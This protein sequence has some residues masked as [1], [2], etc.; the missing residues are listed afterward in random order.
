[1][2][3]LIYGK[4]GEKRSINCLTRAFLILALTLSSFFALVD[5]RPTSVYAGA[6]TVYFISVNGDV[7]RGLENFVSRGLNEARKS[8]ADAVVLEIDTFGG[9]VDSAVKIRDKIVSCGLK[10]IAYVNPRAWSAGALIAIACDEIAMNL[11]SSIGAAETRP[12][13]EKYISAF[14]SEFQATAE[15]KGK[16]PKVAAAMV[17][18]QIEI[19]GLSA[20][21]K[22]LTLTDEEALSIGFADYKVTDRYDLLEQAGF[23]GATE[24]ELIPEPIEKFAGFLNNQTVSIVLL[25]LGFVGLLVEVITPGFGAPGTIGLASLVLFFGSRIVSGTAGG[26]IVI[27]FLV[28]L[29]M[30]LA[31]IFLIPGF[32]VVGV[33]GL[34]SFGGGIVLSFPTISQGI[35]ALMI[36]IVM[37]IVIVY[38]LFKALFARGYKVK[39]GPLSKLILQLEETPD[40]GYVSIKDRKYLLGKVGYVVTPLRPI[41]TVMIENEKVDASSEGGFVDQGMKVEVIEADGMRIVVRVLQED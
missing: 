24:V 20:L 37:T 29:A 13:E 22:I 27:L 7:D 14:R 32:G 9:Y 36:A 35:T 10:T 21:G 40:R 39:A 31:E 2:I 34:L 19:E 28:G 12:N 17:D 38:F 1:M 6:G 26:E 5:L 8:R 15:S 30:I 41:G 18:S 3:D 11:G 25:I 16:D 4:F 33:L 23:K